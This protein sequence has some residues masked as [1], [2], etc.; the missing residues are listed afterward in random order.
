MQLTRL[1]KQ[2][3][4]GIVKNVNHRKNKIKVKEMNEQQK[5]QSVKWQAIES[6]YEANCLS[7]Q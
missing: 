6:I 7:L 1:I 3:S 5:Y 4:H 2:I